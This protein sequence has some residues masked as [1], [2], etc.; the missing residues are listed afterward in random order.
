MSSGDFTY[1]D[2]PRNGPL[3]PL[4]SG[5]INRFRLWL[6]NWLSIPKLDKLFSDRI[7]AEHTQ[8]SLQMDIFQNQVRELRAEVT[9]MQLERYVPPQTPEPERK[10]IKTQTFKQFQDIL[11]REQEESNAV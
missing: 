5:M 6:Y 10:I 8:F 9:R 2:A 11:E 3:R 4:K 1:G 7:Q